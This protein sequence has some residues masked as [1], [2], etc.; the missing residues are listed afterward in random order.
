[1]PTATRVT[2]TISESRTAVA[3]SQPRPNEPT[4][5]TRIKV[6][7]AIRLIRPAAPKTITSGDIRSILPEVDDDHR[8]HGRHGEGATPSPHP[9]LT[10]LM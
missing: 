1:M 8:D 6:V 7:K 3:F 10:S 4:A 2:S 9:P 5:G